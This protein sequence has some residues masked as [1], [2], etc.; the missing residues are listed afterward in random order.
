VAAPENARPDP[1]ATLEQ[2]PMRYRWLRW[3]VLAGS[4]AFSAASTYYFSIRVQQEARSRFETV[5]IGVANDVRSRIRAY[6]D[7]LYA[8]RGLFDSS[9]EVTR[10]EFHRFAQALS[11]GERYPGLT[12]ISFS[13]RVPHRKKLQF[14][15]AV[16]AETSPLVKGLPQFSIKPPGERP[17]YAVL[18]Y[19]EPMGKNV[20]AWGLDLNADPLRRSAIDRARDSGE[21]SS[22]SGVTLIRDS[23]TSVTSTLLR[24]A[25]YRGGGVPASIEERQRLY[26]GIVGS[27]LRLNEMIAA[28]LPKEILSRAQLQIYEVGAALG[29]DESGGTLLFDSAA[30]GAAASAAASDEF[31]AYGVAHRLAVGDREWRLRIVPLKDPIHFLDKAG[32]AAI[33]AALLAIS[34]LLFWLMT[35]VAISESRGAE[36]A[37][38]N[39]DAALLRTLSE[40]LQSCTSLGESYGVV[41]KRLPLLLPDT[42]G[43]VFLLD[44]SRARNEA[45]LKWGALS[46]GVEDAFSPEDCHA[47]TRGRLYYVA[48]SSSEPNCRHFCGAPPESYACAPLHAQNDIIG[49][50]HL[51]PSGAT[52]GQRYTSEELS[53]INGA[54]EY[55]GLA[56]ANLGLR[57]K[58][59]EQAMRDKLTGLY[60]RHYMQEWFALEMRRAQRYGRPIAAIMLDI[61]HFKRFNDSFGHEAGDLVLRELAGT[62]GRFARESDVAC[63]YGGEEFL[64]LMPEC[65]LD[66]ARCKA[67]ELRGEVAKLEL[68]YDNHVLGPVTVSLGV[69]AF[70]DHAKESEEFLRR[71]DEAL[72]AAKQTGRNR[73]VAYSGDMEKASARDGS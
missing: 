49:V 1:I 70:P 23:N 18:T 57:E 56:V 11:L 25:A 41:S 48:N 37:K 58:L 50:M 8:L 40:N 15:R 43:T 72:Y 14:E 62:L 69:A 13:F 55:V 54:S 20:V 34:A 5:A 61:D 64:V 22:S 52:V 10:D 67:E 29:E 28:T 60:N 44:A 21:V 33:L 24:L 6:G 51:Q 17:E 42:A 16:R 36:L 38:R 71:A 65:P 46:A 59:R 66:A 73:V 68:H 45:V 27:T 26:W 35:S 53:L 12:N 63:R 19:I 2:L 30:S 9:K 31:S 32:I 47:V 3:A 39:R 4:L 7:V